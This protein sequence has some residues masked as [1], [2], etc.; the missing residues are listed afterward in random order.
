MKL[1]NVLQADFIT[2][3]PEYE[4]LRKVENF[5]TYGAPGYDEAR[6]RKVPNLRQVVMS[7]V[8]GLDLKLGTW[9]QQVKYGTVHVD[10]SVR[11]SLFLI[12]VIVCLKLSTWG[13]RVQLVP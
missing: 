11:P 10:L 9:G 13:Q 5:F 1:R 4:S 8:G 12:F 3:L 6:Y 7:S 2:K